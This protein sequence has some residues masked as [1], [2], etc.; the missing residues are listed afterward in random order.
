MGVGQLEVRRLP[1]DEHH[2]PAGG[3]DQTGVVGRVG[4]A[5]VHRSE[6]PRGEPLG[7]LHGSQV[8]AVHDTAVDV[9]DRVAHRDHGDR[10]V[11]SPAHRVDD[12]LE[13]GTIGERSCRV[14]DQD[15]GCL[16][17]H[18]GQSG[19]DRRGT[20]VATGDDLR[21]ALD[22]GGVE[23]PSRDDDHHAVADGRSGR[24]R[25]LDDG[26]TGELDPLLRSAE[27]AA[28]TA[29]D[30]DAPD[31]V[32]TRVAVAHRFGPFDV[33]PTAVWRAA[34][35]PERPR[36]DVEVTAAPRRS[37]PNTA[38]TLPPPR[39]VTDVTPFVGTMAT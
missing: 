17:G 6:R 1:V 20:R 24:D 16:F 32:D 2:R 34:G 33:C 8:V 12:P 10:D 39:S 26:G 19:T 29:R 23:V 30:D 4:F 18:R 9:A 14:V 25:P 37:D 36:D 7:C 31:R 35:P 3:L 21:G 13:E 15:D 27:P 38:P 5:D 11:R 22:V 28:R